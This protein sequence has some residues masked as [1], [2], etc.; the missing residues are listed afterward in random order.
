MEKIQ[1]FK[2]TIHQK[3]YLIPTFSKKFKIHQY[4]VFKDF[5][6]QF[7]SHVSKTTQKIYSHIIILIY[8]HPS[9]HSTPPKNCISLVQSICIDESMSQIMDN[10]NL[11]SQN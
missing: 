6:Q 11:F 3:S 2:K 7:S 10:D 9:Y 4:M 5:F 1:K 8:L